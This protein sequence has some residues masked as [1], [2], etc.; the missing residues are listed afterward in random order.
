MRMFFCFFWQVDSVL[1][2]A[3]SKKYGI[4]LIASV[5]LFLINFTEWTKNDRE[6]EESGRIEDLV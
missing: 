4:R 1:L 3:V 5:V 2:K 6:L